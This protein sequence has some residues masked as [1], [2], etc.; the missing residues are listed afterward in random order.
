MHNASLHYPSSIFLKLTVAWQTLLLNLSLCLADL[1]EHYVCLF[2]G[3]Q[4][5]WTLW[6]NWQTGLYIA[7]HHLYVPVLWQ[8]IRGGSAH[9]S[10]CL[11]HCL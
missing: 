2:F 5:L 8:L 7:L 10:V 1:R 6:H 9:P 11:C 4:D 3:R